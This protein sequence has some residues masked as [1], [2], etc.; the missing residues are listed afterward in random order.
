MIFTCRKI[1]GYREELK[2]CISN[3][4]IKIKV[5]GCFFL[6]LIAP[7]VAV[8]YKKTFPYIGGIIQIHAL[9]WYIRS[10]RSYH[11]VKMLLVYYVYYIRISASTLCCYYVV[12]II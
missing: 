6:L 9:I 4:C 2:Q 11:T 12:I 5:Y 1:A 7:I 3:Q 8:L 10:M